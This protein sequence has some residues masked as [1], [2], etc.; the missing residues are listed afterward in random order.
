[1]K[2]LIN[3]V[4]ATFILTHVQAQT[5][6]PAGM[7]SGNW[8]TNGSP[9]EIQ[10]AIMIA[11]GT[12]LTIE[13]GVIVDFQG[14]F[15]LSVMGQLTAIGTQTD[16]ITFTCSN[17]TIGWQSIRFESTL[18]NNDSSKI[19]FSKLLYGK[20]TG[21]TPLNQG[22][23]IYIK[24]FSKISIKNSRISNCSADDDGGGIFMKNCNPLIQDNKISSNFSDQSGGG[25]FCDDCSASI[26]DNEILSNEAVSGSGIYIFSNSNPIVDNNIISYNFGGISGGIH[27]EYSSSIITNNTITYNSS[28][29]P[30]ASYS[31]AGI[32]C[33]GGIESIENNTIKH[34]T[35]NS[36]SGAGGIGCFDGSLTNINNNIITNNTG[37]LNSGGGIEIVD[38]ET[39]IT[40]NLISN[41][42]GSEYSGGGLSLIRNNSNN[43]IEGNVITNNVS[44]QGAGIYL[45]DDNSTLRNNTICNNSTANEGSMF[46]SNNSSPSIEN[47][48][49]YG[50]TASLGNQIY[51]DDDGS[52]PSITYSDLE[53]GINEIEL[54]TNVFYLGVYANNIELDPIFISPSS[55]SGTSFNGVLANWGLTNNSPCVEAGN[56]VGIYPNFDIA[57]N[58]RIMDLTIDI[59]A[60]EYDT[61]CTQTS[62]TL[63]ISI[64]DQYSSPS[65]TYTW[66][67]DGTF[68]DTISNFTGCDSVVVV[69]LTVTH[70][71]S[72][73]E[74][75]DNCGNYLWAA[76]GANYST[77]GTYSALLAN[78]AGCDSIATLNLTITNVSTTLLTN[79]DTLTSTST[80]MQYQWLDCDNNYA[81]IPN[82]TNQSFIV[83]IDGSYSV[84]ISENG[85]TDTS[86]CETITISPNSIF[87]NTKNSSLL[88][89]PNP[90]STVF[91]V[92]YNGYST[93]TQ[94]DLTVTDLSGRT[95]VNHTNFGSSTTIDNLQ[96]G[97]YII[98]IISNQK[99]VNQQ[100]IIKF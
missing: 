63:S 92:K 17:T 4:I 93:N 80:N 79:G 73:S 3:I 67:T 94:N 57:G 43:F 47:C 10:G 48:I 96:Q 100:R 68:S 1:M 25:I 19:H 23:G 70:G 91:H 52:D 34:N 95:I 59:G 64:C 40:N 24:D 87:E 42:V 62:D 38:C 6:I 21:S 76:N 56:P 50:N 37:L 33:Y 41:N 46:F 66:T 77:S 16:S 71:N 2:Y 98:S 78:V 99:L 75:I 86:S 83:T 29:A 58:I 8:D 69:N 74:S 13:P 97:V 11:D 27:S 18:N 55:G 81:I 22:G 15:K 14:P 54:N 35:N 12:I 61:S 84:E 9:Y 90:S 7:V 60:Y 5:S 30:F 36:A 53:G 82:A 39:I 44:Q 85:C 32:V 65:G 45:D 20:A 26:K 88:I 49:I 51:L 89:Y 28:G 31:G 72:G